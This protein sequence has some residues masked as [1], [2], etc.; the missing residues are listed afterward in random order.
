LYG[1]Q[2]GNW[3]ARGDVGRTSVELLAK[4]HR[5][6][7]ASAESGAYG[8]GWSGL[9]CGDEETLWTGDGVRLELYRRK[10][11]RTTKCGLAGFDIAGGEMGRT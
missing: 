1:D 3:D 2:G 6:H 11:G 4:V 10:E 8:R 7:A 9:G 5:P